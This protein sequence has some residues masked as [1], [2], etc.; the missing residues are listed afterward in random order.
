M[1]GELKTEET[2]ELPASSNLAVWD[3]KQ[4]IHKRA[5]CTEGKSEEKQE[6]TK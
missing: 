5:V 4:N 3:Q 2:Q 1:F 6:E